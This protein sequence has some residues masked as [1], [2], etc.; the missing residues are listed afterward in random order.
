MAKA[1]PTKTK[2]VTESKAPVNSRRVGEPAP[3]NEEAVAFDRARESLPALSAVQVRA[4]RRLV[5]PA[6]C[7]QLGASTKATE[8]AEEA[9]RTLLG[10]LDT[11]RAHGTALRFRPERLRYAMDL[12]FDL[13]LSIERQQS[14]STKR[15]FANSRRER[16]LADAQQVRMKLIDALE[17]VADAGEEERRAFDEARALYKTPAEIESSTRKFAAL[18][19]HF[20]TSS[21]PELRELATMQ[22]IDDALVSLGEHA[23]AALK[24]AYDSKALAGA[25]VSTD[26]PAT[27][28]LEG[29]VLFELDALYTAVSKNRSSTEVPLPRLGKTTLRVLRKSRAAPA[30]S[31]PAKPTE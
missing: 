25:V 27:N 30:K 23:A 4:L 14:E 5:S 7:A 11:I 22:S 8:V 16:A 13:E 21:D 3:P 15:K 19:K 6:R 10:S 24:E 12:V 29:R 31:D 17:P 26:S 9:R 1:K 2:S 28:E 18:A 20:L